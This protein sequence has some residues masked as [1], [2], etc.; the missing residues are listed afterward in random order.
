M[1]RFILAA[2]VVFA[3]ALPA[4]A[5]GLSKLTPTQTYQGS[6]ETVRL[7]LAP[8]RTEVDMIYFVGEV[9][10]DCTEVPG[11]TD[12]CSWRLS[13][14]QEGW[15]PLAKALHTG[16]RLNLI[17]EFPADESA[18]AKNSCSVHAQRSNRS[19]L[20]QSLQTY[21]GASKVRSRK[22]TTRAKMKVPAKALLATSRT[23]FELST[24][25]GDAPDKCRIRKT[26]SFCSWLAAKDTYGHG[27]LALIADASFGDQVRLSCA[28]PSD[29]S[30]R[31]PD[32]CTVM[33]R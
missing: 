30:P 8:Y 23:A 16:D 22:T 15:Y 6:I 29:G 19:Y 9:P 13:K 18:R 12:I 2:V 20:R 24:L 32:S 33:V 28:L 17:C 31:A 26:G 5:D 11:A 1:V 7:V 3:F 21:K 4:G 10:T 14:R 25:V 27:T